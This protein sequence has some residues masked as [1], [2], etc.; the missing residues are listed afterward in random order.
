RARIRQLHEL[1]RVQRGLSEIDLARLHRTDE[2]RLSE[3]DVSQQ[4]PARVTGRER[5]NRLRGKVCSVR[6]RITRVARAEQS[7]PC[8]FRNG[9]IP[10][11]GFALIR[12]NSRAIPEIFFVTS[13]NDSGFLGIQDSR[14]MKTLPTFTFLAAFVAL[15]VLPIGIELAGSLQ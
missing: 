12:V 10:F 2:P 1:L 7:E 9:E 5:R 13:I 4:L 6:P 14:P 11:L 15:F 3:S 8:H